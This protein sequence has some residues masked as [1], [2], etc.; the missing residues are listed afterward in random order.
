MNYSLNVNFFRPGAVAYAHLHP[1]SC[2]PFFGSPLLSPHALRPGT[3]T[4]RE[5][6]SLS[7]KLA[8]FPHLAFKLYTHRD[9]QAAL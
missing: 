9:W 3:N 6:V 5:T 2:I 4:S 8:Y 7:Q 1:A